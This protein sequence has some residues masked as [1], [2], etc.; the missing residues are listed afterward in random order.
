MQGAYKI[1]C[2][3][4]SIIISIFLTIVK[5]FTFYKVFICSYFYLK[6]KILCN[7][8]RTV[9][10]ILIFSYKHAE[11][12]TAKRPYLSMIKGTVIWDFVFSLQHPWYMRHNIIH[13]KQI[14]YST[15]NLEEK[16]YYKTVQKHSYLISFG[17]INLRNFYSI[18][19]FP[20]SF[21]QNFM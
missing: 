17:S 19:S 6:L 14:L 20:F 10:D 5:C 2:L 4:E 1:F 13:E 11:I 21:K 7:G 3:I 15:C 16:Q 12:C 9:T 18:S 8:D